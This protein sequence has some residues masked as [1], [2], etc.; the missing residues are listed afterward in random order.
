MDSPPQVTGVVLHDI[1]SGELR[2]IMQRRQELWKYINENLPEAQNGTRK[3]VKLL[4]PRRSKGNLM[5]VTWF[6]SESI[7]IGIHHLT[8]IGP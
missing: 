6:T 3:Y 8:C 2:R 7:P 1:P 5:K 4:I